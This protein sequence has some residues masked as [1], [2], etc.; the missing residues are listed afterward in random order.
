[1]L[2]LSYVKFFKR[3]DW[4]RAREFLEIRELLYLAANRHASKMYRVTN[5][6]SI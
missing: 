5:V 2:H 1:M 3:V 4:L 6:I